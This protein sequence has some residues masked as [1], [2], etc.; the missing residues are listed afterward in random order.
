M[1]L[2]GADKISIIEELQT[3]IRF[4]F[5]LYNMSNTRI[6][7]SF[8]L[9]FLGEYMIKSAEIE[10]GNELNGEARMRVPMKE[11]IGLLVEE[12]R[13]LF[14]KL[15]FVNDDNWLKNGICFEYEDEI[16]VRECEYE[17]GRM[18]GVLR[19]W[20]GEVLIE[21]DVN[22][23]RIYEGGFE[24]YVVK[25]FVREGKGKEF[26]IDE[27]SALYVGGWKNGLR[28]GY[29]SEFKDFFPVYIGE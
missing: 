9:E 21:Y 18:I 16:V 23:T 24:G 4:S 20:K 12:D 3:E 15:M 25:G 14:M 17:K 8:S 26:E 6:N 2:D 5:I 7:T 11:G 13:T 1:I 10:N 27:K 22:G 29:G 28:H 19:E